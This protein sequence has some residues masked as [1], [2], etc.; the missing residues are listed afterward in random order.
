MDDYSHS[1]APNKTTVKRLPTR[2]SDANQSIIA[3]FIAIVM[4]SVLFIVMEP[5]KLVLSIGQVLRAADGSVFGFDRATPP[6]V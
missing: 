5:H 4:S 3:E 6:Q 2:M 1:I